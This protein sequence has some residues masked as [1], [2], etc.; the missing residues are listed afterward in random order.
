MKNNHILADDNIGKLLFRLSAPAT[1]GM[2][3]MAL[4]NVVDTIFI[5]HSV[6]KLGI[7]GISIVFPFQMFVMAIGQ[8]LG[9]GGASLISRSL[10]AGNI[11]KAE[12][13]LG[14]VIFSVVIF[15][16]SLAIFGSFFIDKI[17]L[18]FGATETILPYAR[19]YMQIILFG[20]ILFTF[21]MSSNNIIRS[22]GKAKVAMGT[23]IISA[24][25][26]IILDPIFIFSFKMGVR[27]AAIATVI[28][29]FISVIYIVFFFC[30]GKS[31]LKFKLINLK[32]NIPI[33]KEVFA[34][35]ASAFARQSAQSFLII[36]L[37]NSLGLYGG[38]ISIAVFGVV[39]K[40]IRF[41]IMPIFGIA[42]GLQPIAGFNYGAKQYG[43][44]WKA[45]KLALFSGVTISTLGSLL[46]ISIPG[47]LMK[48]FTNDTLLINEG[49]HS[50][51]I[52]ILA[53][54]LVGFQVVGATVFQA[55]GK[56]IPALFL[57]LSRQILF[58]IPLI[59]ILPGFFHLDGIWFAFPVSDVL[60]TIVTLMMLYR[61]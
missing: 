12:K 4:Y 21:L 8:T 28:A 26:N 10:G 9:I 57:S 11:E 25:L 15:G 48:I 18:V 56:A 13:T 58:L 22:E 55:F 61:E 51:K 14:N 39:S 37:N 1:L 47:T 52:F 33:L 27:G 16:I 46:V 5:G 19:E 31:V 60:A 42:Q 38:D 3:V 40:L 7:A 34:I 2:F 6:G 24:V 45:L 30:S 35:G 41:I 43:K 23:M 44:A 36:V 20:T 17:L 50:L 53:F 49:V 32:F 29:Q 54:P 59:L